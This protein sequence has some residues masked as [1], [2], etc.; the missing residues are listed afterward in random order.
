MD[1]YEGGQ[2]NPLLL[3]ILD[4]MI[5]KSQDILL[6]VSMDMHVLEEDLRLSRINHKID[7]L[8]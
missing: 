6:T 5:V 2:I 7:H 3:E 4:K 8:K 1:V